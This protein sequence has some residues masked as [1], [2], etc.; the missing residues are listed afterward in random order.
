LTLAARNASFALGQVIRG[1]MWPLS[2]WIAEIGTTGG[3]AAEVGM[4]RGRNGPCR[5]A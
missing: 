1:V 3:N 4:A 2:V 5:Q